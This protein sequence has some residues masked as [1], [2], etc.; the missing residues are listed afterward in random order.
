MKG[1]NSVI[2]P[3]RRISR[4]GFNIS[5]S[6]Q[7]RDDSY[8][9][10]VSYDLIRNNLP[11][12][13]GVDDAHLGTKSHEYKCQTC[14]QSKRSCLGHEGSFTLRYPVWN[15]IGLA[16]GRKWL[17]LI[18]FRCG[19]AIIDEGLFMK[20]AR[21]KRLD[22]ASKLARTA[23]KKC[24][25]CG[26][27][28]AIIKKDKKEPLAVVAEFV[29]D[30]KLISRAPLYPHKI[31]EI[32]NRISDETVIKLGK[33]TSSHPRNFILT[34]IK[35][36]SVV[37]RP[38]VRKI[39]GGR[40]TN[41][42]LTTMLQI[43]IRK[44]EAMD[45]IIPAEIDVKYEKAI[46]ELNNA[47]H[48][49]IKGGGEDATQSIAPRLKGK[50]GQFRKN[51]MGKR[52]W[53]MCR[54]T[55]IGNPR[56]RIDEIG[57]PMVFATTIQFEETV[58]EYNKARLLGYVQNGRDA[59][60]GAT[61]IIK[62]NSGAERDISSM[63]D[64]ELEVG[65]IVFR[66]MID[67]DIVNFNRQP[68]LM[69]S[70][71][72]AHK[73]IVIR[74]PTIK[75]IDMNVIACAFYGADFDG[76]AMN[77]I[78]SPSITG[79]N[80]ITE[81]SAVSNWLISH[82][83]SST[84]VGLVDDAIIGSAELT[85][86]GVQ[87]QKYQALLLCQHTS[88]LPSF[89][90]L[91]AGSGEGVTTADTTTGD[92]GSAVAPS[93]SGRDCVS[94]ILEPTPINFTRAAEWYQ[95]GM[96]PYINYD[97]DEIKVVIE[98]GKLL[99][100]VLDKKSI[101]KGSHGGIYQIIANEY[102]ARRALTS[103]YDM[104][105]LAIGYCMQQGYTIGIRDLMLPAAAKA[106]IDNIASDIVNKSKLITD[107]YYNGEIIPP[108]GKTVAE[109]YEERQINALS[110]FDDFTE[111]ILK[112]IDPNT[113]NLFKLIFFGSKG[114]RD[115]MFNMMSSVGQKLINGERIA[116]TFGYGRTSPYTPRFD[117]SP[118]ARGYIPNSYLAG[119]TSTEYIQNAMAARFDLITKALSTS[120]T[121]EQNRKSIKN[122]ESIVTNNFRRA[123]KNQSIVQFV[124]GDDYLDPRK[125]ERVKFPTVMMADEAFKTKYSHPDFPEFYAKMSEE[126]A[127]YRKQFL[128]LERINAGEVMTDDRKMPVDVSRIIVDVLREYGADGVNSILSGAATSA[129]PI[130]ITSNQPIVDASPVP[131]TALST[132]AAL[133]EMVF[134][135]ETLCTGIPYVLINEIQEKR[136]TPVPEHISHA[137]WL[138]CMLIR[139][140]LHPNSLAGGV[141][142]GLNGVFTPA[143]LRIIMDKIRLRYSQALIEPGTAVGM[144]A[145]MSVSEPLTQYA[146]DAHHRSASG[147]TTKTG[148][149]RAK[150]IL[151]AKYA[152]KLKSP[153][154]LI[155][156]LPEYE[157]DKARVQEIA[158]NI[159]EMKCAQFV[160]TCQIFFEKYGNPVHSKYAHEKEHIDE[161]AR[162]NPLLRPA[163]LLH[164]CIRME[165]NKT[166]LI[167]KSMQLEFLVTRLREAFPHLFIIYTP[168]NSKLIVLRIYI[169]PTMFRSSVGLSDIKTVKESIKGTIIRGVAGIVNATATQLLRSKVNPD[170]SISRNE[171]VWGI[172]TV[173]TNLRGIMSN[174]FINRYEVQTDAMQECNKMFGIEATRPMIITLLNQLVP[175]CDRRH[176]GIYADEMT[177]QGIPTSIEAGGLKTR[178]GA[179]VLLRVGFSFPLATLEEASVNSMVDDI[180][181]ITAPLLV[182]SVPRHGT[183]YNPFQIDIE[184]VRENVK[185]PDDLIDSVFD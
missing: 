73:V 136:G 88:F 69:P 131:N 42:P 23:N 34:T 93:M 172:T 75:T 100:G 111:P 141:T 113:N 108:I 56:R 179:N 37:I 143:I 82:T 47:Y 12:P 83:S 14:Y 94:K 25:H 176:C 150:E 4:V 159:E 17:K 97:P 132:N 10:I 35:V 101:G 7:A 15:P 49:F 8:A 28:H 103:M 181:G 158:N 129:G 87:F 92:A 109:Y 115:N 68:S 182:G 61:K 32:F 154:M 66:D 126:R 168:E 91:T 102:G 30:K 169:R 19:R 81:L 6:K 121:G 46:L 107:E 80:E 185:R 171:E 110:I 145:A 183:L 120:V 3:R 122:L 5:G 134:M 133:K 24:I 29:A 1:N 53:N 137:C 50:G 149:V 54:S 85:R 112:A 63:R 43:I 13:G 36:P 162:N 161:F 55:I 160:S 76:D 175:I 177:R 128:T 173:G 84:T 130:G 72:G 60:P 74:D 44:S 20:F 139:S 41:D 2:L 52:V 45:S 22:E 90:E 164:W 184:F 135:V 163:E 59:Y 117:H 153:S 178:E 98:Q 38:D 127:R 18:C 27:L 78:I 62:R 33:A 116:Q 104:Q 138:L 21:N 167:L 123:V 140:H 165:I 89:D 119:M 144:I 67:G 40:S 170:G 16:D 26:E 70:N 105:Q 155:P 180:T 39:G 79:R 77:I 71:I 174:R 156:V 58:Q 147:G 151:G 148:M 142:G 86:S 146:L 95:P 11:Y 65:D 96:A 124:Y 57:I 51:H 31:G 48:D 99:R 157:K 64:I 166:T 118:E 106:E 125:V 152:T 114:K 9:S